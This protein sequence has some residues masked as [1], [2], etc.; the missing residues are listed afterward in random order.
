[1]EFFMAGLSLTRLDR[2]KFY[3]AYHQRAARYRL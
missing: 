3:A 1:L 2:R